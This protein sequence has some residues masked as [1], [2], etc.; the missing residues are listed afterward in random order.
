MLIKVNFE[1][2][3]CVL[4]L[5]MKF[6]DRFETILARVHD[7]DALELLLV[8]HKLLLGNFPF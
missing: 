2:F 6:W 4:D 1:A 3:Y 7:I 5:L 8:R